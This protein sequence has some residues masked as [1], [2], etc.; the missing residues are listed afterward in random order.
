[1]K[2]HPIQIYGGLYAQPNIS[3]QNKFKIVLAIS[4]SENNWIRIYRYIVSFAIY[5]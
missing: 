2:I 3:M 4:K 5:K 1:M